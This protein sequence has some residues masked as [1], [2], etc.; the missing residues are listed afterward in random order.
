MTRGYCY[1]ND[2]DNPAYLFNI[3]IK[4]N[5][6]ITSRFNS[7]IIRFTRNIFVI[8]KS[9]CHWNPFVNNI[10]VEISEDFLA[11]LL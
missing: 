3:H 4:V 7:N 8:Q 10:F 1:D 11:L 2:N 9:F 6:G 5:E